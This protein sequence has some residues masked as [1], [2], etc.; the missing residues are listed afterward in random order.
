MK[1]AITNTGLSTLSLL[2][3]T[4]KQTFNATDRIIWTLKYL[5]VPY[6]FQSFETQLCHI[7]RT[8]LDTDVEI[9]CV[10]QKEWPSRSLDLNPPDTLC[11]VVVSSKSLRQR[12]CDSVPPNQLPKADRRLRLKNVGGHLEQYLSNAH[13]ILIG[14]WTT[15]VIICVLCSLC[16]AG[17]SQK[18]CYYKI[19]GPCT[20]ATQ[21]RD[22]QIS[23][24]FKGERAEI[25]SKN[26]KKLKDTVKYSQEPLLWPCKRL[27]T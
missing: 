3:S 16:Y 1:A 2:S 24:T 12:D 18:G 19:G 4:I 5:T 9:L 25:G 14:Y 26:Q 7:A 13:H 27:C 8:Q 10:H 21:I 22:L 6:A 11:S 17:V 23:F 15:K 20:V